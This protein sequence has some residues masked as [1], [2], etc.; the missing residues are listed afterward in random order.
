MKKTEGGATPVEGGAQWGEPSNY[1]IQHHTALD[2]AANSLETERSI[3]L[4][5]CPDLRG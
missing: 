3:Q 2:M 5:R 1:D 4:V